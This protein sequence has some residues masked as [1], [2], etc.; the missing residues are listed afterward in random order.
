MELGDDKTA[1]LID[2]Y[3]SFGILYLTNCW[4]FFPQLQNTNDLFN[5]T[6]PRRNKK[7]VL[8]RPTH[9]NRSWSF[10]ANMA[11]NT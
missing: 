9:F 10:A 2:F 6:E 3:Y 8:R 11:T 7:T 5:A 1:K 4:L